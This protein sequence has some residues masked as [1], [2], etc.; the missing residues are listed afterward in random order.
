MVAVG[1]VGEM[2]MEEEVMVV[3]NAAEL[4]LRVGGGRVACPH[5]VVDAPHT[6]WEYH[7]VVLEVCV[8]DP[9]VRAVGRRHDQVVDRRV[10]ADRLR[11]PTV[12][13]A[14]AERRRGARPGAC[15]VAPEVARYSDAADRG[16][17]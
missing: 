11:V 12:E 4:S 8:R 10:G 7:H 2:V 13:A 1:M 5:H 17:R 14:R 3:E 9:R 6:L 15:V 16:A